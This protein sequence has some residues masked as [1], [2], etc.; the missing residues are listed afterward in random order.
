M[1]KY[2]FESKQEIIICR[3]CP[4]SSTDP[5]GAEGCQLLNDYITVN[6][7]KAKDPRCPLTKLEESVK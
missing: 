2:V 4:M 1:T 3:A 5:E 7:F 6:G